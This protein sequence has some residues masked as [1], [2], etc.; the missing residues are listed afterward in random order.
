MPDFPYQ[1]KAV[2]YPRGFRAAGARGGLKEAGPDVAL[3]VADAP[4]AAAAVF[5]TNLVVAAPVVV[6][7]E[8]LSRGPIRAVA[9]NSGCANAVTGEQGFADARRMAAIAADA[10]GCAPEQILVCSTG[11]IGHPL[12][13][14]KV[15]TGICAAAAALVSEDDADAAK[16][17][18]TTDTRPKTVT[19]DVPLSGGVSARIGGMCKGS[20]MIAP[21]MATMLGFMTTDA[22]IDAGAL[23]RAL[24]HAVRHTFNAVTV[25]GDTSTNDTLLLMASGAAGNQTIV[26]GTEDF[27]VFQNVLT[28][29]CDSLA[30]QIAWDGEGA[31]KLVIVDVRGAGSEA[32]AVRIARTIAESPLTKTALFGNDPNWGRVLAAAGRAGVPFD[33]SK[34]ELRIGSVTLLRDGEPTDFDAAHA[35]AQIARDE[36]EIVLNLHGG[37]GRAVM[38]TCDFSY[39][40]VRINAEYH[41]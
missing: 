35:S 19:A 4:C 37:P 36:V 16:A 29:A 24:S 9:V 11:V 3:I 2:T 7:R 31:T 40:Y 21:N 39:D 1:T 34:A 8:H 32:G 18:M 12:P 30:R 28:A 5:T 10:V 14:D 41:T 6:S 38:Y 27:E 25:D 26:A 13:L 33:P 17:I 22:A 15:E 20:G 23:Q